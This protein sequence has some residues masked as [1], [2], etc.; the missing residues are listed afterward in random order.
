VSVSVPPPVSAPAS[1]TPLEPDV[2]L[3]DPLDVPLDDPLDVPLDVPLDDPPDV[4]LD[5]P[6]DVPLDDPPGVVVVDEHAAAPRN[7]GTKN[8]RNKW[9]LGICMTSDHDLEQ[10]ARR[11]RP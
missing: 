10:A 9:A 3:D 11:G 4:P 1:M 7:I 6:P 5:E 8:E 2:P